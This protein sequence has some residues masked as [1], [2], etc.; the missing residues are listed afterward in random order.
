LSQSAARGA[1]PFV[2]ADHAGFDGLG[3][4]GGSHK[5][6]KGVGAGWQGQAP[7]Q[8]GGRFSAKR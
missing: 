2:D 5:A 7:R 3:S 1:T 8:T 6:Q 4:A